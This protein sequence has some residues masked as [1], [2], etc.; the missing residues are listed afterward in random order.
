MVEKRVSDD[1]TVG[2][3]IRYPSV[4]KRHFLV[5]LFPY[6]F[7]MAQK[8][9]ETKSLM[10]SGVLQDEHEFRGEDQNKADRS[11]QLNKRD[12]EVKLHQSEASGPIECLPCF[13]HGHRAASAQNLRLDLAAEGAVEGNDG[14]MFL[15]QHGGFDTGEGDGCREDDEEVGDEPDGDDKKE[16]WKN[17][18]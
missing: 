6:D 8:K 4:L 11:R 12:L 3:H 13:R 5:A 16:V 9:K 10:L 1:S 18:G 2:F 17:F 14:F 7:R 15:G